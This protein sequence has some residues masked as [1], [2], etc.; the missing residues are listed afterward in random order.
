MPFTP[1]Q[2]AEIDASGNLF[3]FNGTWWI[4]YETP[5]DS[6]VYRV[7]LDEF[8]S[9]LLYHLEHDAQG[10]RVP[11]SA[12]PIRTSQRMLTQWGGAFWYLG[13]DSLAFRLRPGCQ[14]ESI[15]FPEIKAT[16]R[17]IGTLVHRPGHY[18]VTYEGEETIRHPV[19]ESRLYQPDPLWGF[20]QDWRPVGG[21]VPRPA[22]TEQVVPRPTLWERLENEG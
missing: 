5:S 9:P 20:L 12:V 1:E 16:I 10:W 18:H 15:R 22:H 17:E 8:N 2:A 14:V 21:P 11:E 4:H 3:Q 6:K 13:D 7:G 19:G